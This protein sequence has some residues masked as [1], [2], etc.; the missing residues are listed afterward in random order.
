MHFDPPLM[1][2]T[3]VRRY[4]RFLADV[5]TGDGR[6]FTAHCPNTG[7]MLGC[8]T[9]GA[10]I[11]LSHSPDPR[12]K[13]AHTWQLVEAD[14]T[15]VGINTGLANRLV[16]EAIASGVISALAHWPSVRR[17]VRYGAQRSRIDL[18]LESG[19]RKCYV[20]VKNV[21]AAVDDG[22]AIFPDAVSARGA[23][24]LE[25]L[26]LMRREGHQAALVFCVQ[27]GDVN[28]VR[29]ADRIDPVYGERLREAADAGV[30]VMAYGADV[31]PAG[32]R[33][34]QPLTVDLS[35]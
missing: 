25:E 33:L 9:P 34:A 28:R 8:M 1:E 16:E 7:S 20:E 6:A 31:G 4:K 18:L 11:W 35:P 26:M 12:R 24:H 22:V 19:H 3:L 29:P 21:T 14:G 32:I 23:R 2:A 27:R 15:A 10:R 5:R 30:Q 13:Y 17:E